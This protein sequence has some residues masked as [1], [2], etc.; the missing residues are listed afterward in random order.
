MA[1]FYEILRHNPQLTKAQVLQQAQLELKQERDRD[2][3]V[4]YFWAS[5]VLV[6]NWL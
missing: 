2:W 4:P 1:K 5:Y 3:Q 6:G